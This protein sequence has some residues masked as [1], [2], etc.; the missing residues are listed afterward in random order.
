[1]G[2]EGRAEEWNKKLKDVDQF[3][4]TNS[5]WPS[6]TALSDD[7]NDQNKV[8]IAAEEKALAQWWSRVKYYHKKFIENEP[9][10]GMD[11]ARAQAVTELI[12]KHEG[13]E[14]DGIWSTRYAD[15]QA[16]VEKDKQ[17]WSYTNKENEKTVRWWNQQ[18]T[19]YRKFRKGKKIGG[20]TP[21]RA[22]LLEALLKLMGEDTLVQQEMKE[23][24]PSP[25]L[26]NSEQ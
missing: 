4:I 19:F 16:K 7:L 11:A 6:T 15:C 10:P 14:R 24:E 1:M 21:E 20:M 25:S 23:D 18:K 9:A 13:L 12:A 26:P 2:A 5:R 3:A 22:D 17:L 8:N